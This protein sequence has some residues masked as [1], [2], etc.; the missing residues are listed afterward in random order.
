M[1]E[2]IF[3]TIIVLLILAALVGLVIYK[4]VKDKKSGK[5]SC[6][7]NCGCC[8]NAQFCHSQKKENKN[9]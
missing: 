1:G 3:G 9:D 4:M 2:N 6:G 8:A 7:C 5:N